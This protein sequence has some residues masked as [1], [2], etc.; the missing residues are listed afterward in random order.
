MNL[1]VCEAHLKRICR[2]LDIPKWPYRKLQAINRRIDE[3]LLLQPNNEA[4]QV[5]LRQYKAEYDDIYFNKKP[6]GNVSVAI[7]ALMSLKN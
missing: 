5:K 7:D 6:Q 3:L 1:G 4:S 2:R